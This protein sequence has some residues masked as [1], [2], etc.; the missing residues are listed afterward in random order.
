[1][2]GCVHGGDPSCGFLF[3]PVLGDRVAKELVLVVRGAPS[4]V[5]VDLDAVVTGIRRRIAK[6]LEQIGVE[7]CHAGMLVI[8]HGHAVGK[9]TVDLGDGTVDLAGRATAVAAKDVA[10]RGR[11]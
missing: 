8:E 2:R 5:D 6:G 4:A 11:R 10:E 1:M 7:V 3:R 9:G